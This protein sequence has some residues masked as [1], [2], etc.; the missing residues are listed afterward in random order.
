[1]ADDEVCKTDMPLAC[2]PMWRTP[3]VPEGR[4]AI[5]LERDGALCLAVHPTQVSQQAVDEYNESMEHVGRH[6][7]GAEAPARPHPAI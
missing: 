4:A 3:L 1:M 2:V 6:G 7:I 5:L